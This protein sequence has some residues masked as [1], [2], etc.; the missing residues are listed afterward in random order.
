LTRRD[1]ALK[2]FQ[3]ASLCLPSTPTILP[4]PTHPCNPGAVQTFISS[5]VEL[6]KIRQQLQR[7]TPG[8]ADYVG[9]LGMLRRVLRDEGAPGLFRGCGITLLRD[10]PSYGLYFVA[11]A[12]ACSGLGALQRRVFHASGSSSS[13]S[14]SDSSGG[15]SSGQTGDL[16]AESSSGSSGAVQFLSGGLA[17]VIAWFSVYPLDVGECCWEQGLA[18]LHSAVPASSLSARLSPFHT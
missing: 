16:V 5:P 1:C 10:T 13:S 12:A 4:K 15:S 14:S 8:S 6:L 18:V 17:G 2:S 11:Y 7:S 9:P 3:H